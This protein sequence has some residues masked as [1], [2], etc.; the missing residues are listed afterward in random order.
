MKFWQKICLWSILIFVL[1]FN[2]AS[3]LLI[4]RTHSKLLQQ[5]INTTLSENMSIHSTVDA[6]IP[7][8][9]IYDS[10]DYEK[11]V[12]TNIGN[13][14]VAKNNDR[15]SYLEITDDQGRVIYSHTDYALP[16]NREELND[17]EN[18]EIKSILRDIDERT[19]L[20]TSNS[21]DIQD[22]EY[23][24][25]YMKDVTSIYT[26]RMEQYQFFAK[27]DIAACLFYIILMFIISKGLTKPI[28]KMTNTAKIIA[29][30]NF[31]E[32][33]PSTSKDEL[34]VL[35]SNFNQMAEFI[36][37]KIKE[38]EM[39]NQEKERFIQH[40]THELKTPLTSII[41][42]ANFLRVT[43]YQEEP[44]MDGINVIYS[45]A[46]RLELLSLKL[47]DL[48]LLKEDQFVL[49][50]GNLRAVLYELE[51]TLKMKAREKRLELVLKGEDSWMQMDQ[52]LIKVLIFNL[53]D[54]ALKASSEEQSITINVYNNDQQQCVLEVIDQG[55]GMAE[56]HIHH[57]FEP[58]YVA[59]KAR[60]RRHNG[61][62]LG[63]SICQSVAIIHHGKFEVMSEEQRGTMIRVVFCDTE[64]LDEV[65]E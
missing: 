52:D 1:I 18:N 26:E 38:L 51:F 63:L 24:F 33:V 9:Q 21:V 37:D 35:A 13:E 49:Q 58:F 54:N 23:M 60:T 12:L 42:Y 64:N 39:H 44:F 43:K 47:M 6:I 3:V 32:R 28:D 65:E 41:G 57:I 34:G 56:E 16:E 55:I 45:E 7:I 61:A 48:I 30:G 53:V 29:Q 40:F 5:E 36:E 25:T 20:F 46:K 19:I 27:I 2:L 10:L 11:T 50:Q 31:S 4:E 15:N 22:K 59:D 14:F 8:L 17:L 62:G